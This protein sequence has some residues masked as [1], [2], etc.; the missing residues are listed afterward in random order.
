MMKKIES[1][2]TPDWIAPPGETI[3]EN[4]EVIGMKQTELAKRMGM[5]KEHI[6]EVL[7]GKS[8]IT[9]ET[10]IKFQ[11]VLGMSANFILALENTYRI[12]LA[13][14]SQKEQEKK[15][16]QYLKKIPYREMI[17]KK[18]IEGG[19]DLA[20]ISQQ[21][22]QF[23][24]IGSF[25]NL[26]NVYVFYRKSAVVEENTYS[27]IAWLRKGE[28]EAQKIQTEPFDRENLIKK[29]EEIR[30]YT[31][32]KFDEINEKL[33]KDMA[34]C[35]VIL[36]YVPCLKK[37]PIYGAVKWMT[38]DKPIIMMSLRYKSND[39]FWFTLMHE[40]YHVL[41]PMKTSIIIEED[42][43]KEHEKKAD[44]F[45]AK[46]LIPNE[47]YNTFVKTKNISEEEIEKFSKKVNI[48]PG[49]VVGRLQHDKVIS[50]KSFNN[51]KIKYKMENI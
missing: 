47:L 12:Y 35:G 6:N 21:V 51:F 13:E 1:K 4:L 16:I 38:Q 22:K 33:K 26:N 45:A 9:P 8:A 10:A 27:V 40:I 11:T 3:K 17:K 41:N 5:T 44:S 49:I 2:I 39:H 46:I 25:D 29:I 42:S 24:G 50:Y 30:T 37:S 20:E 48:A 31:F 32:L 43:E 19:N 34:E 36:A 15:E 7:N 28:L 18:W 23:L 14:Q